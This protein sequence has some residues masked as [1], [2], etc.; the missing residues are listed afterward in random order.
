MAAS[1]DN[2]SDHSLAIGEVAV[3][4]GAPLVVVGVGADM[5]HLDWPVRFDHVQLSVPFANAAAALTLDATGKIVKHRSLRVLGPSEQASEPDGTMSSTAGLHRVIVTEAGARAWAIVEHGSGLETEG[6]RLP[7]RS[8]FER[9]LRR[10]DRS[11][12]EKLGI[13][14]PPRAADVIEA[15]GGY[16]G[17]PDDFGCRRAVESE[18]AVDVIRL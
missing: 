17:E 6:A 3:V 7:V 18:T 15:V 1:D 11:E 14:E 12:C 16:G 10:G 13:R 5:N 8:W 9:E 2:I 4:G